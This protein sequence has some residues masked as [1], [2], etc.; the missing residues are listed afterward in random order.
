MGLAFNIGLHCWAAREE[1]ED[2]A[3]A[4][5]TLLVGSHQ[6]LRVSQ[7]RLDRRLEEPDFREHFDSSFG[8][9][10]GLRGLYAGGAEQLHA[11]LGDGPILT[12][13]RPLVEYFLSIP[14]NE[15]G[16]PIEQLGGEL[17]EIMAPQEGE[18]CGE[19]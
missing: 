9:F 3:W 8:A 18:K 16:A 15:P 5:G 4:G 14:Q 6:P 1:R 17:N 7:S 13:D 2:T 10:G 11:F 19:M 12:D